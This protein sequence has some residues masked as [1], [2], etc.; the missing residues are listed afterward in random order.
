MFLS[1]WQEAAKRSSQ[2]CSL[3]R[4]RQLGPVLVLRLHQPD[5]DLVDDAVDSRLARH[6]LDL[7]ALVGA[8]VVLAER[9]ANDLQPSAMI[10]TSVEEQ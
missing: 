8:H 4:I 5:L 6:R 3:S 7:L 1:V 9:I 2:S 10:S